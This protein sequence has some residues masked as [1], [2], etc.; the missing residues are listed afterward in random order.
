MAGIDNNTV[1]YLRGDSFKD[2]SPKNVQLTNNGV[3]VVEND[4]LFGKSLNF[5][6]AGKYLTIPQVSKHKFGADN[7]TIEWYEYVLDTSFATGG[8]IYSESSDSTSM[9]LGIMRNANDGYI[10]TN[11]GSNNSWLISYSSVYF[12]KTVRLKTWVHRALVRNGATLMFF[13]NG[14]LDKTYNIGTSSIGYSNTSS[15]IGRW[16]ANT[17]DN[18]RTYLSNFRIS[19]VARYTSEFT[20]PT[21]IF[22][23]IDINITNQTENKIDFTVSK[24]GQETIN[25]IEVL[26]N[27]R[28]SKTYN[29]IGALTYDIDKD[30]LKFGGKIK[31]KVTFDG[32]YTEE[33]EITIQ[34]SIDKLPTSSS[35]KELIDRQELLTNSIESQ[36]NT[37]KSILKSK[38]VEVSDLENK[39]SIL[40]GKVNDL[41]NPF[42]SHLYL[43]KEGDEYTSITGGWVRYTGPSGSLT[44]NGTITKNTD[45]ILLSCGSSEYSACGVASGIDL[46]SY[47]SICIESSVKANSVSDDGILIITTAKTTELNYRISTV[48]L[49]VST[50]NVVRLNI[51]NITGI[52]YLCFAIGASR[53]INTYKIWLEK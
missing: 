8:A 20:P 43:Y 15:S 47:S 5:S 9:S 36:K 11:V 50:K 22:N 28:L 27:N 46:T 52:K 42:T 39:L 6:V 38:N 32:N 41:E 13:T 49:P 44:V 37:L 24:I 40:I 14:K 4:G 31:I 12:D 17:T 18:I 25:R 45:N 19:N 33:K 10:A 23:S 48:K 35:L 53:S 29:E 1:L 21:S 3:T 7:F 2:L 16:R 51:S 34:N 30:T 26:V